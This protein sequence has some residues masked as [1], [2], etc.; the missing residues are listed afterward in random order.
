MALLAAVLG[1]ITIYSALF[2]TGY[3]LYGQTG[4]ALIVAGIALLGGFGL[5]KIWPKLKFD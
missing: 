3:L 2:A 5:W 1:S 4:A